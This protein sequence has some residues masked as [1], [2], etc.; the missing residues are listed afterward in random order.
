[1]K[2][3]KLSK[4]M[5]M[6]FNVLKLLLTKL[7]TLNYL[8]QTLTKQLNPFKMQNKLYMVLKN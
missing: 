5:M 3:L 7:K 1:M 2:I 6:Q 8:K 4:T